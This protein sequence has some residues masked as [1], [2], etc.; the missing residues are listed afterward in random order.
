MRSTNA[1]ESRRQE[2]FEERY[3][4]KIRAQQQ[5]TR[6][7]GNQMQQVTPDDSGW[8]SS[9]YGGFDESPKEAPPSSAPLP[10][11]PPTPSPIAIEVEIEKEESLAER[12][13][14]NDNLKFPT[15]VLINSKAGL[16]YLRRAAEIAQKSIYDAY[17]NGLGGYVNWDEGPHLVS[18]GRKELNVWVSGSE[19]YYGDCPLTLSGFAYNGHP[20][21]E[22]Y[23][24]IIEVSYL[25]NVISHPREDSL[26]G[27][28]NVDRL[29]RYAQ[30]VSIVLGD[31]KG[32]LEIRDIRDALS[33]DANNVQQ[34]IRD[35][36][37]LS[38]QP[39]HGAF[40]FDFQCNHVNMFRW[41]LW[42]KDRL[43]P[44]EETVE[45]EELW[46]VAQAWYNQ[47]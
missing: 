38:V 32:A 25:R 7:P 22:V 12:S 47:R 26:Q 40:N 33:V 27:A 28:E 43:D 34:Y 31:E 11:P 5:A 9:G 29:L 23:N 21:R 17:K 14:V 45:H 42:Y 24:T 41:I 16:D 2:I 30:K 18:L 46:A 35:L 44:W 36:Y 15:T 1:S 19:E 13:R 37:Y 8:G 39:Y 3:E 10:S 6:R 20:G 4:R